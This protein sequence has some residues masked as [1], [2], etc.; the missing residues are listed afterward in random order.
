MFSFLAKLFLGFIVST[1]VYSEIIYFLPQVDTIG[2]RILEATQI[3]THDQWP[4]IASSADAE[5]LK[6]ELK[7]SLRIATNNRA[8]SFGSGLEK[9]WSTTTSQRV[10]RLFGIEEAEPIKPVAVRPYITGSAIFV[11]P[12][13]FSSFKDEIFTF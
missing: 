2:T 11:V 6:K 1:W 3:P 7:S 13:S 9:L 5:A 10:A 8:G 4:E 12:S